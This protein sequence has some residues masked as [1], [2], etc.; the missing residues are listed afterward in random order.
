MRD[1]S[2]KW[3]MIYLEY[4]PSI[5]NLTHLIV[6]N[7]LGMSTLDSSGGFLIEGMG[8][9]PGKHLYRLFLMEKSE[10]DGSYGITNGMVRNFNI[11]VLD[12]NSHL[13]MKCAD[14]SESFAHCIFLNNPES[15]AIAQLYDQITAPILMELAKA[16]T[17]PSSELKAHFLSKQMS[18]LLLHFADTTNYALPGIIALQL[19]PDF[20]EAFKDKPALFRRFAK[21]ITR[22]DAKSPYVVEFNAKINALDTRPFAHRQNWTRLLLFF[23]MGLSVFLLVL[24]FRLKIKLKQYEA[25]HTQA[26]LPDR[27]VLETLSPKE[28]EVLQLL[29]CGKSNKEIAQ[30]LFIETSTVK[31][32][33][34]KIYQKLSIS[35]RIDAR[36]WMDMLTK[37]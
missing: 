15:E 1:E 36:R 8:L 7:V 34:N 30:A 10:E 12:S 31:S 24:V 20:E 19:L 29:A 21:K 23:F 22:L 33:V 2:G 6:H 13:N 28:L 26:T 14:V 37:T 16:S 5:E 3:G 4:I 35:T 9:P 11:V 32:H 25:T 27:T 17:L 18:D